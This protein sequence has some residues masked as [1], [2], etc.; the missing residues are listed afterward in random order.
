MLST[1]PYQYRPLTDSTRFARPSSITI[2]NTSIEKLACLPAR[3]HTASGRSAPIS[4]D[5]AKFG[6]NSS[7]VALAVTLICSDYVIKA[8][9]NRKDNNQ[10]MHFFWVNNL[11]SWF[12]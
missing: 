7:R 9:G 3:I 5:T 12:R 11:V 4:I 10:E 1:N 2:C 8:E 6:T